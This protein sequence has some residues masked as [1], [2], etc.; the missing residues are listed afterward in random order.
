M[1]NSTQ[2][3]PHSERTDGRERRVLE[4]LRA[5]GRRLTVGELADTVFRGDESDDPA[6]VHE[7]LFERVLP[8]LDEAGDV[9][10]DESRGTVSLSSGGA[11]SRLRPDLSSFRLLPDVAT[12]RAAR[13][14]FLSAGAVTLGAVLFA[15]LLSG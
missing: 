11:T 6:T 5:H 1:A 13:W 2:G 15:L 3:D 12:P 10:F 9:R 4:V 8:S 14:L 7:D